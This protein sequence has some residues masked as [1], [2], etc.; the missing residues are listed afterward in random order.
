MKKKAMGESYVSLN[1]TGHISA[2]VARDNFT[3]DVLSNNKNKILVL[4]S[5][6]FEGNNEVV[7]VSEDFGS[8][9]KC[10]NPVNSRGIYCRIVLEEVEILLRTLEN[11]GFK[12]TQIYVRDS[13]H[14]PKTLAAI[15]EIYKRL[16]TCTSLEILTH[17]TLA[18]ICHSGS[19]SSGTYTTEKSTIRGWVR[20]TVSL[21]GEQVHGEL[22]FTAAEIQRIAIANG[23]MLIPRVNF[24][25]TNICYARLT[26][27]K[28]AGCPY[29]DES[30]YMNHFG[31]LTYDTRTGKCHV[32]VSE[33][34]VQVLSTM[35]HG[36]SRGH[37][38]NRGYT[39]N[40]T[41]EVI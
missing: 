22:A 12:P 27:G 26:F 13:I 1:S 6:K 20:R 37:V 4:G 3:Y 16:T 36:L 7:M 35:K 23:M 8:T 30:D 40:W 2:G 29:G 25:S 28:T 33:Q 39:E 14:D 21:G 5:S 32:Q 41:T 34:Q 38:L 11:I 17:V 18:D 31:G 24:Y 10:P 9:F 19:T 15:L